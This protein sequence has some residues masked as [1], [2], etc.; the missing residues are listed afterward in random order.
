M[1]EHPAPHGHFTPGEP[2][3]D[4]AAASYS[5]SGRDPRP[6]VYRAPSGWADADPSDAVPPAVEPVTL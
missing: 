6:R 4:P 1:S 5:T 3:P 2:H